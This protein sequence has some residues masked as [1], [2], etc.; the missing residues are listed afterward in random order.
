MYRKSI[1]FV[2]FDGRE[3]TEDFY[4]NLTEAEILE[5]MSTNN[6]STMD[7]VLE[8]MAKKMNAKGVMTATKDLI[9][10]AY[11][12]KSLDGRRFIKTAEVKANFMETNAYSVLFMELV[13][14][15]KKASE[16]FNAIIPKGL[17]ENVDK[18]L[19][20][21]PNASPEEIRAMIEAQ[22]AANNGDKVTPLNPST[23]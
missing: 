7:Q 8:H 11:G 23:K 4:F 5:W 16:F 17:A 1:T 22:Q 15:A 6:E 14:D 19:E 20:A 21:N 3:R 2:D 9:E 13:T 12:E 18:L 10:R